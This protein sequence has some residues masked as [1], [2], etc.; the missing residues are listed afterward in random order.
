MEPMFFKEPP[1]FD[2]MMAGLKSMED[3]I[4]KV[5]RLA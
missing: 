4:N 1:A 2:L 3:R 5:E